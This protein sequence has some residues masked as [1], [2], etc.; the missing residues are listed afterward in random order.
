M[1]IEKKNNEFYENCKTMEF[2]VER[3]IPKEDG[4]ILAQ[5]GLEDAYLMD[6]RTT[7]LESQALVQ[8]AVCAGQRGVSLSWNC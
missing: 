4:G 2:Q 1:T 7:I 8:V 5:H 6:T 3:K